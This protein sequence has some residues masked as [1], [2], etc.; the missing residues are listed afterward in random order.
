MNL[1]NFS[2]IKKILFFWLIFSILG[3]PISIFAL[4]EPIKMKSSNGSLQDFLYLDDERQ[5]LQYS[6]PPIN[7]ETGVKLIRID[8]ID[9]ENGAYEMVFWH[10]VKIYQKNDP[11]D[12]S[13]EKPSFHY[14][15]AD[16]IEIE[17]EHIEPHYFEQQIKGNFHGPMDFTNFPFE[18]LTLQIIIEPEIH[19]DVSKVNFVLDPKSSVD[20]SATVPGFSIGEFFL[21]KTKHTHDGI[22]AEVYSRFIASFTIERSYFGSFETTILPVTMITGLALLTF[23]IP[24]NF[25]PRIYLTAPLLLAL[26]YLHRSV[27][28]EIPS[29]GYATLFDK[30]LV[31]DYSIFVMAI[32]SLALQMRANHLNLGPNNEKRINKIMAL[33]ILVVVIIEIGILGF[34]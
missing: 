2:K 24:G 7:Y 27:L 1:I 6:G 17:L 34:S 28:D 15:N 23:Y 29:V 22:E 20:Q 19:Q 16:H 33:L 30:V 21:E 9:K 14:V 25:T 4:D 5:K 13:K 32:T 18:Q 26:V 11:T 8:K 10:W 31:I 12:F 3:G